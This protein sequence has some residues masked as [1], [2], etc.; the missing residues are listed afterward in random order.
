M[1]LIKQAGVRSLSMLGHQ[2]LS[3]SHFSGH[4]DYFLTVEEAQHS[5]FPI[6]SNHPNTKLS[7]PISAHSVPAT[8]EIEDGKNDLGEGW[9]SLRGK[10]RKEAK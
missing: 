3:S 8:P 1:R 9:G 2:Q 5:R 7:H 10:E 4:S 6:Q